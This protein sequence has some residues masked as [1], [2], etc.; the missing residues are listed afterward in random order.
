M[1][2][3]GPGAEPT[4]LTERF[5]R[6]LAEALRLHGDQERKGSRVPYVGHL[7]G[8]AALVLHFGGDEEQAIAG[9]LHDA[10]EDRGGRARLESIRVQFG[11]RVAR[12]VEGCTDTLETPKP[13]W[14]PRKEAYLASLAHKA[15]EVL[16]VSAADKLD[17]ARAIVAD[18]RVHGDGVWSRFS[19]GREA[20]WYHRALVEGFRKRSR[21]IGDGSP[22]RRLENLVRELDAAVT[23]M[24]RLAGTRTEGTA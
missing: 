1:E 15:E 18:L 3:S 5:G 13:E 9:L 22:G 11:S 24:E 23:E 14:R 19:G 10:A 16:L 8:T 17:N 7:L 12:I 2:T 21:E 6:A 4:R 20:L